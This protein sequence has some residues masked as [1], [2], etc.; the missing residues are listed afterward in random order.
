MDKLPE[1]PTCLSRSSTAV[2][3]VAIIIMGG[4][5]AAK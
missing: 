1:R 4:V 3:Q 2:T 5:I